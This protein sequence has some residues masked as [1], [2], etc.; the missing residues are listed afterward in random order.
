MSG[1]EVERMER[2]GR[3]EGWIEGGKERERERFDVI[4]KLSKSC[5]GDVSIE[6]KI[7]QDTHYNVVK[8][9]QNT[10]ISDE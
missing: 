4:R 9:S 1:R 8:F 3:K 10:I 7:T 5:R 2:N 6:L